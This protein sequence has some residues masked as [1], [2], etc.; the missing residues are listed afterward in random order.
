MLS[1]S[2]S[3]RRYRT[4]CFTV[5]HRPARGPISSAVLDPTVSAVFFGLRDS[6]ADFQQIRKVRLSHSCR[7]PPHCFR[8]SSTPPLPQFLS[9]TNITT[10]AVLDSHPPHHFRCF[11]CFRCSNLL[12]KFYPTASAVLALLKSSATDS[13]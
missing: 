4:T 7:F 9:R 11:L 13:N 8:C 12:I 5:E 10:S 2:T 1:H 6:M 3:S